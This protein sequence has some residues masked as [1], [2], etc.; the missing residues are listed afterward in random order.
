MSDLKILSVNTRCYPTDGKFCKAGLH[1]DDCK[2]ISDPG[3][4]VWC[5]DPLP[6]RA[7]LVKGDIGDYACYVGIGDPEWVAKHGDKISF[8]EACCHF[9]YRQLKRE[10]YRS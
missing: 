3:G 8:E 2:H 7:V 5:G 4:D 9:P 10:K 6:I 1:V